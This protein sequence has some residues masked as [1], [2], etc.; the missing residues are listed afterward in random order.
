MYPYIYKSEESQKLSLELG[1]AFTRLVAQFETMSP[2]ERRTLAEAFDWG[3]AQGEHEEIIYK[4]A[5][6]A[7]S[8]FHD[9][10]Y[11]HNTLPTTDDAV[12]FGSIAKRA[13]QQGDLHTYQ[14]EMDVMHERM[15]RLGETTGLCAR[16]AGVNLDQ[17][18]N[19]Y[20]DHTWDSDETR[21]KL[22]DSVQRMMEDARKDLKTKTV[23]VEELDLVAA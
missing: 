6:T 4:Q 12:W 11:R 22:L 3:K 18:E 1:A 20:L 19:H 8:V 9:S 5:T 21:L 7:S 10:L 14:K 13:E 16:W 23:R 2:E 17:A 15:R